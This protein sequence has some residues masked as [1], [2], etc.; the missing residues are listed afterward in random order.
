MS[1]FTD[2][3]GLSGD[4]S[5]LSS[6]SASLYQRKPQPDYVLLPG[7]RISASY[8]SFHHSSISPL[9]EDTATQGDIFNDSFLRQM[10]P[11]S[12]GP[13]F[14]E[15]PKEESVLEQKKT[16][17]LNVYEEQFPPQIADSTA[18][19]YDTVPTSRYAS[20]S[21]TSQSSVDSV[22]A[23]PP[24]SSDE[25]I[26]TLENFIKVDRLPNEAGFVDSRGG[27]SPGVYENF[28]FRKPL[29]ESRREDDGVYDNVLIRNTP[30]QES[31]D[32]VDPST[33]VANS[34]PDNLAENMEEQRQFSPVKQSRTKSSVKE[35]KGSRPSS[36]LNESYEWSKVMCELLFVFKA[37]NCRQINFDPSIQP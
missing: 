7:P 24:P 13:S 18:S 31:S 21:M 23:F 11:S 28:D 26:K 32:V 37:K 4:V 30:A 8:D 22:P 3:I 20:G 35:D 10:S 16:A 17:T 14:K 6:R 1:V 33:V 5:R 25:A 15:E 27:H 2:V 19:V 29:N 34:L 36:T 12:P 9:P